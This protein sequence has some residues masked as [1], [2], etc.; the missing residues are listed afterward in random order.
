MTIIPN[1][2][3]ASTIVRNYYL[4]E[5]DMAVL[6]AVGVHYR[7]NLAKV[8]QVT[9]E[10]AREVLREVPGGVPWFEPFIRFHTFGEYRVEFNVILRVKEPVDQYI[11]TH[12]F[13]R[14]LHD[15]YRQEGIDIPEPV[16]IVR[17]ADGMGASHAG[18]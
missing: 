4:P 10:V 17:A 16:R 1:S 14:R 12:E 5:L 11:V 9:I 3:L 13:I 18:T 7:S 2:K 15:R 6:V 8:E